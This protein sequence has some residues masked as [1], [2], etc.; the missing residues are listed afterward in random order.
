MALEVQPVR[1]G[2]DRREFIEL[3][4]RLHATSPHW[5]PPL[6]IE[7]RL[8][9]SPRFNA[10]FKHGEAELFLARREGRV[11]GRISAHIDH[12]YNAFHGSRWGM[13][14]FF[15]CEDDQEAAD[16]LLSAAEAWHRERDRDRMVGP[17]D[18][19]MND[20][21]GIVIEG[22]DLDAMIRQPWQPPYYRELC[23]RAGLECALSV[24]DYTPATRADVRDS[25]LGLTW[26]EERWEE[27]ITRGQLARLIWRSNL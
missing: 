23:E 2:R 6:R 13:W 8:F 7:R 3:P 27:G 5:T 16:A 19:V 25:I 20:E 14:G 21:S 15:E 22:G 24:Y 11:V 18:F 4:Y 10:F 9:L 17:M 26:L 12:A 1:S